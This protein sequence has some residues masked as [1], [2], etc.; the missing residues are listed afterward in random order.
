MVNLVPALLNP[1]YFKSFPLRFGCTCTLRASFTHC[2]ILVWCP[3]VQIQLDWLLLDISG[4]LDHLDHASKFICNFCHLCS[5]SPGG[6]PVA[7]SPSKDQECSHPKCNELGTD[8]CPACKAQHLYQLARDTH[9]G[10]VFRY[11]SWLPQHSA[12]ST[13]RTLN[14][15]SCSC[16]L[17]CWSFHA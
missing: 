3:C 13:P 10:R 9:G 6:E 1:I 12:C 7:R 14:L 15:A 16:D 5:C 2:C 4:I 17:G 8:E 11:L